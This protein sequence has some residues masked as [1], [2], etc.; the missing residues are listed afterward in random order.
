MKTP[1][2][3]AL[4]FGGVALIGMPVVATMWRGY[5]QTLALS[6]GATLALGEGEIGEG[7][8][9]VCVLLGIALIVTVVIGN[10]GQN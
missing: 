9:I 6:H 2:N 8:A 7:Y 3:I 10:R 4:V 1:V 5:I